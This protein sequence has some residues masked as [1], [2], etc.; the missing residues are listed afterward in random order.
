[1]LHV[2]QSTRLAEYDNNVGALERRPSPAYEESQTIAAVRQNNLRKW[3]WAIMLREVDGHAKPHVG[4]ERDSLNVEDNRGS[5]N[6][7]NGLESCLQDDENAESRMTQQRDPDDAS[8]GKRPHTNDLLQN[9]KTG[10]AEGAGKRRSRRWLESNPVSRTEYA[11]RTRTRQLAGN[12]REITRAQRSSQSLNG[13]QELREQREGRSKMDGSDSKSNFE[14]TGHS[15]R[16]DDDEQDS[17]LGLTQG[18]S[19]VHP[20]QRQSFRT[21]E[22]E[23]GP[24]M[25]GKH[26]DT[27]T[28]K[29]NDRMGNASAGSSQRHSQTLGSRPVDWV[30]AMSAFDSRVPLRADD[31]HENMPD[32][33]KIHELSLGLEANKMLRQEA[34]NADN[35][36]QRD[37]R[38]RTTGLKDLSQ[39]PDIDHDDF[40]HLTS[41]I[42][43]QTPPSTT[44]DRHSGDADLWLSHD[45]EIPPSQKDETDPWPDHIESEGGS[46]NFAKLYPEITELKD[47]YHRGLNVLSDSMAWNEWIDESLSQPQELE[48]K[49]D[50]Q[51]D[52]AEE[53]TGP[54]FI[55]SGNG[56]KSIDGVH[57]ALRTET[58]LRDE[59]RQQSR[60]RARLVFSAAVD[61][62]PPLTVGFLSLTPSLF[63]SIYWGKYVQGPP[64][65]LSACHVLFLGTCVYTICLGLWGLC[66][67]S[68]R[69]QESPSILRLHMAAQR[70]LTAQITK[71]VGHYHNRSSKLELM[72]TFAG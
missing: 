5:L 65:W 45:T 66:R 10:S 31:K 54:D 69:A 25:V 6:P 59:E 1:M 11:A 52:A 71:Y 50:P 55:E 58:E 70:A 48:K 20:D 12:Y 27:N 3:A 63:F 22:R 43:R 67:L 18:R 8:G 40:E 39:T 29:P 23:H 33:P 7:E 4:F 49:M 34:R 9:R 35:H 62:L 51:H 56:L 57:T 68:Q 44:P 61:L 37:S 32:L 2:R 15:S 60:A 30:D 46:F 42:L 24:T 38:S 64:L 14:I 21:F 41:G 47:Q 53:T 28:S 72:L 26:K 36:E 13:D 17:Q 16:L 19:P